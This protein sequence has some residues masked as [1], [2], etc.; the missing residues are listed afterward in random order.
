MAETTITQTFR[1][2]VREFKTQILDSSDHNPLT[3]NERMWMDELSKVYLCVELNV[4]VPEK[5]TPEFRESINKL[6]LFGDESTLETRL[7]IHGNDLISAADFAANTPAYLSTIARHHEH[8]S[9]KHIE[10]SHAYSDPRDIQDFMRNYF[11]NPEQITQD[12]LTYFL[13]FY[14][15]HFYKFLHDILLLYTQRESPIYY[16]RASAHH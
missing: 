5:N 2:V 6:S 8:W 11:N 13:T 7:Y 9:A 4:N 3:P 14:F 12:E 16:G 15:K 10:S 1:N